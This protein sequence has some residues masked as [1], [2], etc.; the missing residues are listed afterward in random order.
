MELNNVEHSH[1][2]GNSLGDVKEPRLYDTIE[3]FF[4]NNYRGNWNFVKYKGRTSI[5]NGGQVTGISQNPSNLL[6]FG[7]IVGHYFSVPYE[8]LPQI[9][10]ISVTDK[11]K[12]YYVPQIIEGV[13]VYNSGIQLSVDLVTN[14]LYQINSTLRNIQQIDQ[15][16][17][18]D[19]IHAWEII[20]DNFK[21]S[22]TKLE[23]SYKPVIYS[24]YNSSQAELAWVFKIEIHSPHITEQRTVVIGAS[25]GFILVNSKLVVH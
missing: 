22:V 5:I 19:Q 9:M 2:V 12:H 13:Q 14:S 17:H 18:V 25:T 8:Q 24:E 20:T 15:S 21:D 23:N 11:A 6:A 10:M 3:D 16:V 1:E 7:R 4:K